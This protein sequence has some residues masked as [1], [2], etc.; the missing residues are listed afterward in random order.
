MSA[1]LKSLGATGMAPS[2][3]DED[4]GVKRMKHPSG[5]SDAMI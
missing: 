3:W 2:Y 5:Y 4:I 1:I